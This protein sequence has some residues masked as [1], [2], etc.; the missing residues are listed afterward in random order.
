MRLALCVL[1]IVLV[2][3]GRPQLPDVVLVTL[4]TTRADRIGAMGDAAAHTPVLDGLAARGALFTRAFAS[5]PLTLPSHAT[6]M[7]GL[8]PNQ[9]GIHDNGRYVLADAIPT[10]AERLAARGYD[11]AAFVA[12]FVLDHSFG[13]ARGFARYDDEVE[14]TREPLRFEVPRRSGGAVTDRALAWLDQPRSRPFFVWVHY[15]DVHQ[16]RRPARPF[17]GLDDPYAGALATVDAEVGRLL[18]GVER[19]AGGRQTLVVVVGD[20]GE[21]LGEH[22]EGTHGVLAYDSTL[23]VPLIVAGPGLPAGTRSDALVRT[24]DVAPTVLAAT[25]AP[26]LAGSRGVPLQRRLTASADDDTLGYFECFGPVYR[27][28]WARLGGV[29]TTRWKYT[30]EPP[31]AELYDT[32]ADPAE[33]TNRADAEPAVSAE[34]AAR[35]AATR[36]PPAPAPAPGPGIE[37]QLAALGYIDLA[38]RPEE[39]VAAPDP[40]RFVAG[41]E[42]VDAAREAAVEGRVGASIQALEAL[43]TLP[44][45]R[46]LALM[47]LASVDQ[48]AG[49]P[50]DAVRAAGQLVEITDG[51]EPRILLGES[52]LAAGRSAEALR[53]IDGVTPPLRGHAWCAPV[54]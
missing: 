46:P 40:R 54:P 17:D 24:I 8:D 16:P 9:H 26:P 12:A 53:A 6:I 22:D 5:A 47:T 20:H 42:L 50:S 35:W 2:A 25:G 13:L 18:A 1:A 19:A 52:L 4:D 44:P 31:P 43:A 51:L 21:G 30:A 14:T 34:L 7:T 39:T 23:H 45:L 11:T 33:T 10:V 3:C 38:R 36:P 32:V 49:R 15:Y 29:R 41:I 27:M 28:G 37:E 48:L